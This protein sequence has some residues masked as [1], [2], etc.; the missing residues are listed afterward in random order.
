MGANNDNLKE[1]LKTNKKDVCGIKVFMGSSTGNMLVDDKETLSQI[2]KNS[3]LLIATHCEDEQTIKK[4][5]AKFKAKYGKNIPFEMHPI[6][7]SEEACFLSSSMAIELAKKYQ[8][9]LHI[10]HISTEKELALFNN[11]P[12]S[13]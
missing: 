1:V 10:L 13:K 6:I 2:F 7:R 5:L 3:S 9:R 12:L 4:N 11:N 8:S